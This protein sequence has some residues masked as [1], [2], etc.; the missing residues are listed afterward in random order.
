LESGE[1]ESDGFLVLLLFGYFLLH[2]GGGGPVEGGGFF[3]AGLA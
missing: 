3:V 2:F 1:V